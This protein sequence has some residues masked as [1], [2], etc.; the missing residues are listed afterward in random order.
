MGR[1]RN[2]WELAKSSWNVL[3][4]DKEL[5]VLPVIS[6]VVTIIV[7]L[8]FF[9][10]LFA[11]GTIEEPGTATYVL[12]AVFYFVAAYITIFFNT[13]LVHVA[14]FGDTF[15]REFTARTAASIAQ[16]GRSRPR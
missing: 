14:L 1:I 6:G 4:Q 9:L 3:R 15:F 7:A 16:L 12:L 2:T 11:A 10:P 8:T 13:A 5:L